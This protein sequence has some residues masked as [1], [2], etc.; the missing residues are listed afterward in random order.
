[1]RTRAAGISGHSTRPSTGI[2]LIH[3]TNLT[4]EW[5]ELVSARAAVFFDKNKTNKK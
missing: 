2:D 1:V 5:M 3:F 4:I